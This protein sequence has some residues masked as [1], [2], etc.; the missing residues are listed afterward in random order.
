MASFDEIPFPPTLTGAEVRKLVGRHYQCPLCHVGSTRNRRSDILWVE[1]P[2]VP[3]SPRFLCSACAIEIYCLSRDDDFWERDGLAAV[4][5][6]A[7]EFKV[8]VGII[9]EQCL[10][11]Q[12]EI[13][14]SGDHPYS[15]KEVDAIKADCLRQLVECRGPEV[16]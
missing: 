3:T 2:V 8:H 5:D 14:A 12:L 16:K 6:A 10:R 7:R 15:P 13:L 9:R 1:S 11:H 4:A